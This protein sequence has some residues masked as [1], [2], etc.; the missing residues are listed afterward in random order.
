MRR[1]SSILP[2]DSLTNRDEQTIKLLKKHD[3]NRIKGSASRI[4][5]GL[6]GV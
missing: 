1:K 4:L 6:E 5:V 2:L 3:S